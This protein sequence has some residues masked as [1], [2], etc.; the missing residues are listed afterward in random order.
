METNRFVV[1]GMVGALLLSAAMP[2]TAA[3]GNQAGSMQGARDGR[4]V[5]NTQQTRTQ[6]Q[7]RLHQGEPAYQGG[8]SGSRYGQGYESRGGSGSGSSGAGRSGGQG[9]GGKH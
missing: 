3:D 1:L 2:A 5:Q 7:T 4:A 8:A 9:G 6:E